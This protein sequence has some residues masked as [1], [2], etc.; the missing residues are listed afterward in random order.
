MLLIS[1]FLVIFLLLPLTL[2]WLSDYIDKRA[3][4]KEIQ[5]CITL[6]EDII[7]LQAQ[8]N[9]PLYGANIFNVQIEQVKE[10]SMTICYL[11]SYLQRY[12]ALLLDKQ[13]ELQSNI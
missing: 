7:A 10:G 5:G 6:Y 13:T 9:M 2:L 3:L 4:N 11:K 1:S 12:R 8:M